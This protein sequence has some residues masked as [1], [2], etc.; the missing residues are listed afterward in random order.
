MKQV[1]LGIIKKIILN[2]KD[3]VTIGNPG[4]LEIAVE[5]EYGHFDIYDVKIS[6]PFKKNKRSHTKTINE[7]LNIINGLLIDNSMKLEINKVR[8]TQL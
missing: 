4:I 7:V 1:Q 2:T 6:R 3:I 5:K 8:P